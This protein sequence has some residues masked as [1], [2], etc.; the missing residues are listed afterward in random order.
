MHADL[1]IKESPQTMNIRDV[2]FSDYKLLA[3]YIN[4]IFQKCFGK[5][6]NSLTIGKT[7]FVFVCVYAPQA[8]LS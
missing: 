2:V 7:V 5:F 4:Y 1:I 3:I 8:N 6:S